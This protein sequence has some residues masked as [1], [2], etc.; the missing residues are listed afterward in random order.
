[1]D[2]PEE[3]NRPNKRLGEQLVEKGLATIDQVDIAL[4]EQKKNGRLIGEVL[5]SL[6]FISE[7]IMRDMLGQALGIS[8]IDLDSVVPDSTALDLIPKEVAERYVV[9]P[10]SFNPEK[11]HLRLAMKMPPTCRCSIEFTH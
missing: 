9:V 6:G 10:I 4:T 2:S 11:N 1:M 8:S 5:V 3:K 7:S